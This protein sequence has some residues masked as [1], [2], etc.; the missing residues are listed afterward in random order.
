M[1]S[2]THTHKAWLLLGGLL[3]AT[4]P[5]WVG[6]QYQLHLASL[7]AVF[8]FALFTRARFFSLM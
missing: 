1:N 8:W 3:I 5:G 4:L 6:D 7:I 2:L